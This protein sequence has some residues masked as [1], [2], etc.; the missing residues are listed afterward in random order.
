MN[1]FQR[2]MAA[3][4]FSSCDRLPVIPQIYALSAV[5]AG[6]RIGRYLQNGETMAGCQLAVRE[7][8]GHDALF[9]Y[10]GNAVEAE[11]LGCRLC[12]PADYYP[13]IDRP[14]LDSWRE[15]DR[16]NPESPDGSLFSE[17]CR[18]CAILRGKAK[19]SVPVV[20]IVTGPVTLAGQILGIEKLLFTLA[21]EPEGFKTLLRFTADATLRYGLALL[22]AGAHVIMVNDPSAS[23]NVVPKEL[24]AKMVLPY[25]K[26]IFSELRK[27]KPALLWLQ[28]AGYTRGILKEMAETGV[29]LITIDYL[30]DLP[31]ARRQI[32]S[33]ALAGNIKPLSFVVEDKAQIVAEV[34]RLI[35]KMGDRPGKN[36]WVLS[37]GCEIP[38]ESPWENVLALAE[39]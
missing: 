2:L 11:A 25:H 3:T 28:I 24:Y 10:G 6:V 15:W 20:A 29:D 39:G 17:L 34:R 12:Y 36:G 23:P 18:A 7:R 30:V 38:P 8:L 22:K 13:H 4:A 35:V 21:D 16:L 1:S 26:T 27:H 9:V 14:L 32:P 19:D 33:I 31:E 37:S 5:I